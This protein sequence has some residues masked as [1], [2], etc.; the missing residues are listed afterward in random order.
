MSNKKCLIVDESSELDLKNMPINGIHTIK[1][2]SSENIIRD[3]IFRVYK[4]KNKTQEITTTTGIPLILVSLN[5]MSLIM[6]PS[7]L[8]LAKVVY[9]YEILEIENGE[10]KRFIYGN[11]N[12]IA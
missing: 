3:Y 8:G 2:K 6:N 10:E 5:E 1:F 7:Q 12:I 4:D 11:L 9:Y